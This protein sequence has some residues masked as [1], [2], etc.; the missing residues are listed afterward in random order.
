[1]TEHVHPYI[2]DEHDITCPYCGSP[3]YNWREETGDVE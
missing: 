3:L 1:M 2:D